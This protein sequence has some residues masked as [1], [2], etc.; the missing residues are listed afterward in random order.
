M[1]YKILFLPIIITFCFSCDKR[2]LT[3]SVTKSVLVYFS[4]E[5]LGD[6]AYNDDIMR[7]VQL[8]IL[9]SNFDLSI[10]VPT[11]MAEAKR[12]ILE[13]VQKES[14]SPKLIVLCADIYENI[15]M[16]ITTL[17]TNESLDILLFETDNHA[18]STYTFAINNYEASYLAGSLTAAFKQNVS[19]LCA[20]PQDK[21]ISNSK[22]GFIAGF[23]SK[24]RID[25]PEIEIHCLSENENEGYS[26]TADSYALSKLI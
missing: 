7:G 9:D 1:K 10:V 12:L 4:P 8:S 16:E 25:S 5:G 14:T 6:F 24:A 13:E 20:N 26:E 18:A 19:I 11:N 22:A 21:L 17:T 3:P 15:A 23:K 2:D